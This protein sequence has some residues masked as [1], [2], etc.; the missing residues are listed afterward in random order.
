M[1]H[2]SERDDAMRVRPAASGP[3]L[4]LPVVQGDVTAG[5]GHSAN[6]ALIGAGFSRSAD[7]RSTCLFAAPGSV[8]S[9]MARARIRDHHTDR[10]EGRVVSKRF[11][12]RQLS[13]FWLVLGAAALVIAAGYHVRGSSPTAAAARAQLQKAQIVILPGER[14]IGGQVALAPGVPAQIT[15]TNFT[16][17]FHT[18]NVRELG[19][20]E[21]ILPAS[22][23]QPRT[24]T[25]RFTARK[26]G[27][28]P[29]HCLVCPSGQHGRTHAMGGTLD[30][31][32]AP[33]ALT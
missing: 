1:A 11:P 17:D 20:R 26:R 18:F 25:F 30:L 5:F 13:V 31:I 16:H 14:V 9:L 15:V 3:G 23:H 7:G 8:D 32:I 21:L 27:F 33:Q 19:L 28:F 4:L 22:G 12:R 24:T 29:W 10:K 2:P 6:S